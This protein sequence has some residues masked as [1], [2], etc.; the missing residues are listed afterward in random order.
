MTATSFLSARGT[1]AANRK[2]RECRVL[3]RRFIT[4]SRPGATGSG[5]RSEELGSPAGHAR[6]LALAK[7]LHLAQNS[8]KL[9]VKISKQSSD[10][11]FRDLRYREAPWGA[12][13]QLRCRLAGTCQISSD[14]LGLRAKGHLGK[15]PTPTR[16]FHVA[17]FAIC[18]HE[19]HGLIL[20]LYEAG[21][22]GQQRYRPD[23]YTQLGKTR[24][25]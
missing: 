5:L 4:R 10:A 1:K 24:G 7:K 8:V 18:S 19:A 20:L 6:P 21:G 11:A 25:S 16:P 2:P 13:A 12:L 15:A 9:A 3:G 23:F 14:R 17:W 22:Q